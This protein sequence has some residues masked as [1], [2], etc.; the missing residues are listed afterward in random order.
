M[1][2]AMDGVRILDL[3]TMV[4]GPVATMTLADQ[5]ADVIKVESPHGDLMRHFSRGRNGMNPGFLSCNRNKRSLAVDLKSADGLQIIRRLIATAQVL[6]HNFRPGIAERIGLGEE[7]VRAIQRDIVYVSITGYGTKGPYAGQRAYDPVIQAMSGL[8]DIQRDRDTRRP[9]MVRTIIADYT[10]ALTAAQAITAA[11]FA[12]ERTGIGQ[13]VRLSMLDAMIA[14]LWP[15]AMPSLTFVGN[16]SDPSD[17]EVG[18]DLV[19]ATQD[20]YIT[21]A[22]LSDDE[23]AGMCRALNRQELIDDP[24]FKTARDR[25][26]NAVERRSI[27]SAELEKWRADEILPRLL[28]ND[29]PSAPVVS[30]FELLQDAQV[31]ENQILEVFETEAF[32][33]VRMP[34][35]AAQFGRTPATVRAMAPML[36][37]DNSAILAELGYDPSDIARLESSR[38]IHNQSR[39]EPSD[40]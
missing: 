16:E 33:K 29:V 39:K 18:P 31:R 35:P 37:A 30:R 38:V 9:R 6:V 15:E 25:S 5:G 19:F 36:G 40:G 22:A 24:R 2:G 23:W 10:T 3:T 17:G 26:I 34:R 8:A 20:R 11:L 32:G 28:A 13:H 27:T 21:A 1:P 14:Y 4:A 12:R 7:A